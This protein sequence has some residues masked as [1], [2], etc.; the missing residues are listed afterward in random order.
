MWF[1]FF[2]FVC[3]GFVFL[4][5]FSSFSASYNADEGLAVFCKS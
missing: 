4:F 3:L 5:Y 1:V 2:L